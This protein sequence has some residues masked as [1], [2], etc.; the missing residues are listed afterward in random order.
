[1]Q[2]SRSAISMS[3]ISPKVF[4]SIGESN[5]VRL[6]KIRFYKKAHAHACVFFFQHDKIVAI[7]GIE[8]EYES[9]SICDI[10][11]A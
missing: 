8:V 10:V 2:P 5:Q 1:M 9:K 4:R 7:K 11:T 3:I 6:I